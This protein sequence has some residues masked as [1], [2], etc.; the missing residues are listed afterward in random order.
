MLRG[1]TELCSTAVAHNASGN[2]TL[3]L[4]LACRLHQTRGEGGKQSRRW[5]RP[6]PL[7]LLTSPAGASYRNDSLPQNSPKKCRWSCNSAL[8]LREGG[9][10]VFVHFAPTFQIQSL[11]AG[12][13]LS[14]SVSTN[15]QM[16]AV[17]KCLAMRSATVELQSN[18]CCAMLICR[19]QSSRLWVQLCAQNEM[20]CLQESER[21][22]A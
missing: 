4:E 10:A 1:T 19:Q 2:Q 6:S 5:T 20:Y 13:S 15:P 14:I 3:F 21:R 8:S 12:L 16:T 11:L 18:T 17:V 22:A 9:R 7:S